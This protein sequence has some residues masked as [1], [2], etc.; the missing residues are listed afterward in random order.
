MNM[1]FEDENV[2]VLEKY[3]RD[4]TQSAPSLTVLYLKFL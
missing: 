3:G 1:N 4:I 2:N